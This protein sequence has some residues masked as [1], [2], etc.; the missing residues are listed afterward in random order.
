M[1]A[2]GAGAHSRG[3]LLNGERRRP[4]L[5]RHRHIDNRR[6]VVVA[7]T[8]TTTDAALAPLFA[9]FRF[10]RWEGDRLVGV[11]VGLVHADRLRRKDRV[12]LRGY[13]QAPRAPPFGA[14]RKA[15]RGRSRPSTLS[16]C[17]LAPRS[18]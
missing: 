15:G 13:W 12:V 1:T 8:E 7:D 3:P 18:C 10:C 2:P 14:L 16:R 6:P 11:L 4:P 5:L 9:V 17:D